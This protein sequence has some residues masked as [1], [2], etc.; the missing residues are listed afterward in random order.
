MT[1]AVIVG[2]R[3][4]LHVQAVVEAAGANPDVLV[5]DAPTIGNLGYEIH[6]DRF[7]VDARRFDRGQFRGWLRRYAPDSWGVGSVIGSLEAV[8][9]QANMKLLA[10]F[11]RLSTD[12]WLTPL[13]AL[14]S[15]EDRVHQLA[16]ARS[17]GIRVPH[18]IVASD[19]NAVTEMLGSQFIVK[20][21]SAGWYHDA[22]GVAW[23]V[24]A[25]RVSMSD[26]NDIDFASAP[27]LAQEEI[28]ATTH[29]RVVTVKS[30]AWAASLDAA[31]YPIDWRSSDEA[32]HSWC[33]ENAPSVIEL[34]VKLA[35]VL[36][37]GF[38]SQDWIIDRSGEPVFLDLNPAGQWLFLPA[39]TADEIT[40][41][42]ASYLIDLGDAP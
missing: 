19:P 3:D 34:A 8:T 13:D 37:V 15:A 5:L 20:P 12:A 35:H 7:R 40:A 14:L 36:G 31:P 9:N 25:Q 23:A 11:A 38:S 4:D 30:R 26:L 42:I 32:H 2:S 17:L 21:L 33:V 22:N 28:I 18:T 6:L 29:I 16:I 27:F 24:F 41:A 1:L 10:S 39:N